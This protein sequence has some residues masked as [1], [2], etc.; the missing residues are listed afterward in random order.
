MENNKKKKITI[1]TLVLTTLVLVSF[2]AITYIMKREEVKKQLDMGNKYLLVNN[3]KEAIDAFDRVLEI[4]GENVHGALGLASTYLEQG[5][6]EESVEVLDKGYIKTRN[7]E[8]NELLNEISSQMRIS[9]EH[10]PLQVNNKTVLSL[11]RVDKE[12]NTAVIDAEWSNNEKSIGKL[13]ELEDKKVV[14][15]AEGLGEQIVIAKVG[16]IEKTAS[17]EVLDTIVVSLEIEPKSSKAVTGD[18]LEF[19]AIIKDQLGNEA[20]VEAKWEI[21]GDIGELETSEG[22]F[23]KVNLIRDGTGQITA[24]VGDISSTAFI[25]VEKR[26][27][28]ITAVILG[29]GSITRTPDLKVYED[30]STV[31]LKAVA[32]EGWAFKGWRG[33]IVSANNSIEVVMDSN[34][35]LEA[36]F[37]INKYK[38]T[39]QVSGDGII[40][41]DK[42][43]EAYPHGSKVTLTAV[44]KEH[45]KFDHWEGASSS[46]EKTI[47]LTMSS[48][49]KVKAVFVPK[50]YPVNISY[51]GKGKVEKIKKG[52][53]KVQLVAKPQD[54]WIF[55]HWE[56]DLT[57]NTNPIEI[58][59]KSERNI[60]A[61]FIKGETEKKIT[62]NAGERVIVAYVEIP[63]ATK[64]ESLQV[65]ASFETV[66]EEQWPNLN[67]KSSKEE[68]FGYD[69]EY[70]NEQ[71]EQIDTSNASSSKAVYNG[72]TAK[73]EMM[74]FEEPASGRWYIEIRNDGGKEPVTLTVKSNYLMYPVINN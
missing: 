15:T 54:G 57:G 17:I 35:N 51:E 52:Q 70:L 44:A 16:S 66:S 37:E 42:V 56:K 50:E 55:D 49:K 11:E 63:K 74:L 36:I 12:G 38:L 14:F 27:F 47:T 34:I 59:V 32:K 72:W 28:T 69:C 9:V 40:N 7:R 5:R 60:K 61:V 24:S 53:F 62:V 21:T 73:D 41:V 10:N 43:V 64:V 2:L 3:Y 67:I 4:D 20:D 48:H 65:E 6:I 13:R 1:F 29:E 26:K 33:D 23:N 31:K 19:E 18:S 30:G 39:T 58:E 71:T 22:K 8:I 25:V 45:W 68:W 46:K